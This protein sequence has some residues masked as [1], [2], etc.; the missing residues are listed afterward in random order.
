M[1]C[2]EP[3]QFLPLQIIIWLVPRGGVGRNKKRRKKRRILSDSEDD[4]D[5]KSDGMKEISDEEDSEE[6]EE[7]VGYDSDENPIPKKDNFAGL[8]TKKGK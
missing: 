6:E 4:N 5:G 2:L 7:G 8:F 1:K 3:R